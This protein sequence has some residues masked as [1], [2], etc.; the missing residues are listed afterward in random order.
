M[1]LDLAKGSI[2]RGVLWR[3]G[4]G[5]AKH[6]IIT[7]TGGESAFVQFAGAHFSVAADPADLEL[8]AGKVTGDG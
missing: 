1:T 8:L 6:G 3:G 4:T 5:E 2:G 7:F